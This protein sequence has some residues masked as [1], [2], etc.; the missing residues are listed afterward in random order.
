MDDVG[1]QEHITVPRPSSRTCKFPRVGL[2]SLKTHTTVCADNILFAVEQ[3]IDQHN[4][5]VIP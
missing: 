2:K 3:G 1:R 4:V 5:A